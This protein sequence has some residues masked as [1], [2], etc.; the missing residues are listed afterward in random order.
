MTLASET[1]AQAPLGQGA[2]QRR[3]VRA[4][5][6]VI[7]GDARS[8]ELLELRRRLPDRGMAKRFF[9]AH[10]PAGL[11][12]AV[13]RLGHGGDV[14]VGCALRGRRSGRR[15]GIS[16]SWVAWADCDSAESVGRLV[17]FVPAPSMVVRSGAGGGRHAYWALR[18]AVL[19][20]ELEILNRR[21]A[22]A[23][24]ADDA[25]WDATR[26]LRPPATTNHKYRPPAP[27]TLEI[28]ATNRRYLLAELLAGLPEFAAEPA[29]PTRARERER[30][31][32][33]LR[34]LAPAQYV[35]ALLGVDVPRHRKVACPFH[36][37]ED[38]SLHVY[39]R[40]AQGWFCFSC[41]RGGS[42][43]DLAAGLWGL[44]TR[45]ES[46]KSLRHRLAAEL[47]VQLDRPAEGRDR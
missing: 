5:V 12:E 16:R 15:D 32:D 9:P 4:W 8:G 26:I 14:Y 19:P 47:G 1:P 35:S 29:K 30:E 38:P 11:V 20:P 21:L 6:D 25:C 34:A 28:Y 27:V 36:R 2:A 23:L 33:P 22:A 44:E 18:E 42:A 31:T 3:A 10:R 45:G 41:R 43:Y 24:G 46:F 37:D 40:A 39:P 13:V 17:S 7:A